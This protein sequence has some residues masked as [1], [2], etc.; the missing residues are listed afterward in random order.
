MRALRPQF[1]LLAVMPLAAPSASWVHAQA[2]AGGQHDASL[3]AYRSHLQNLETVVADCR[4]QRTPDACN[5]KRVGSDDSV[6]AKPGGTVAIRYG[7][8]REVLDRAGRKQEPQKPGATV[9]QEDAEK[10]VSVDTLLAQAQQRLEEDM[11]QAGGTSA[12]Q[13]DYSTERKS[14]AAIL[15]RREY[16]GVSQMSGWEHF[17]EW[18]ENLLA[19]IF[20]HLIRFGARSLW[21][22][23]L[24]QVL[25]IGLLCVVLAWALIRI[26]RRSRVR[27]VPDAQPAPNAPSARQ[28]QL[29]FQD[30]QRM[31]A[32]GLWRDAIHLL[33]WAAISRLESKHLW[34]A[35][36][37]RTP[38]EYLRLFP[39][40]D[41]RR[42]NLT[43]LTRSF[44]KTWYGGREA[45]SA[46][47]DAALKMAAGLG[48]E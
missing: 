9:T 8:L 36:S 29:W 32:Q 21:I 48:V 47:F 30:A 40:A 24:L 39:A 10:P 46:E 25:L 5:V 35:D 3:E 37:A 6:Q 15:S 34:P 42:A 31:A 45:G 38:R 27:L 16:Q 4:K 20:G 2:A 44:E 12:Q 14:I 18:I 1:L 17:R 13:S 41:P 43:G 7:W 11:K 33:Y 22:A 23:H 19:S 28:W 26:E